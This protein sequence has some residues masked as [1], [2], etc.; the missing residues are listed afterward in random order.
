MWKS[1]VKLLLEK[2]PESLRVPVELKY[3]KGMNVT[4]IGEAMSLPSATVRT[5][6]QSAKLR[7]KEFLGG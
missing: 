7:L 5:R 3:Y 1:T 2:L 6:L 4:E